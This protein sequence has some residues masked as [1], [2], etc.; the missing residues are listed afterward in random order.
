MKKVLGIF[1]ILALLASPAFAVV[2]ELTDET[3]NSSTTDTGWET[4]H[5]GNAEKVTYF[6]T[7]DSSGSTESTTAGVTLQA[8]ADGTNWTDIR[9]F[10]LFGG[11]TAQVSEK[12]CYQGDETYL[13]WLDSD[14]LMPH[15]RIKVYTDGANWTAETLGVTINIVEDK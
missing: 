3:L 8:S 13:M 5:V 1:L 7:L 14:I 9:W 15:L 10:D 2:T 4:R 6:I 12:L 11:T